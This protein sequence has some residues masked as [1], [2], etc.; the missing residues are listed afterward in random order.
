M[1]INLHCSQDL[2]LKAT[3]V[4][5]NREKEELKIFRA[6][7]AKFPSEAPGEVIIFSNLFLFVLLFF[8]L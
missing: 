8:S 3:L 2:L 1:D 6:L 4:E 5:K 7:D